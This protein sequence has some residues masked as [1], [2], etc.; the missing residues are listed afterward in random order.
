MLSLIQMLLYVFDIVFDFWFVLILAPL[1]NRKSGLRNMIYAWAVWAVI[2]IILFFAPE[3]LPSLAIP[4][5]LSTILF[6]ITGFVLI[7]I[8]LGI[9]YWKSRQMRSKALG[10][11]AKDLLDLPPGEF[12]EMAAELYRAFGH[13]AQKTGM[14]GDHGVD[15]V[16]KAKDGK[17]MV[18]QCKRWR[19]PVGESIVRDFYGVMQHEKAAQGT[20]IATSGF[21]KQAIEWA[22]GKPL[23]L[24]DGNEFIKLWERAEKKRL[25]SQKGG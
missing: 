7:A 10:M 9:R 4:E 20:I 24:H 21:T 3:P 22:K 5:P 18:V 25:A 13:Q 2:R 8:W 15:V 17:K 11:S 23:S 12:E 16:V 6:F 1:Q 19:K 14:S